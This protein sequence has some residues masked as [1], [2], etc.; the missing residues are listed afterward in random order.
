LNAL[1][2]IGIK[3]KLSCASVNGVPFTTTQGVHWCGGIKLFVAT[4]VECMRGLPSVEEP[5]AGLSP[6]QVLIVLKSN[7]LVVAQLDAVFASPAVPD[8]SIQRK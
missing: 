5:T 3:D 4:A 8:F 1:Q 7:P 2:T 6:A